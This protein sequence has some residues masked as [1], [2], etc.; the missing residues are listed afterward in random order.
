MLDY[1]A[2]HVDDSHAASLFYRAALGQLSVEQKFLVERPSGTAAGFG[3]DRVSFFVKG[4]S[5]N[6][7]SNLA[8]GS[9]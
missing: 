7:S 3:R 1:I 9:D 6:G 4:G 2:I 8:F 5:S